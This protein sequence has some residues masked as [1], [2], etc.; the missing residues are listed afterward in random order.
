VNEPNGNEDLKR[1]KLN[2]E[3]RALRGPFRSN[4]ALWIS[5]ATAIAAFLF[6]VFSLRYSRNEWILSQIEKNKAEQETHNLSSQNQALATQ[7]KDLISQKE[8]LSGEIGSMSKQ[9]SELASLLRN[10][11]SLL[12][13]AQTTADANLRCDI[14]K[15][16]ETPNPMSSFWSS[17]LCEANKP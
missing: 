13:R 14:D 8:K 15:L 9:R 10:A 3:I 16:R 12:G 5:C 2:L 11:D 1:E 7:N 17:L 4:P 6:G